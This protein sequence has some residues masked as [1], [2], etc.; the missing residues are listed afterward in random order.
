MSLGLDDGLALG[1]A[2]LVV[3]APVVGPGV[4][5]PVRVPG[6]GDPVGVPGVSLGL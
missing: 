1:T 5:D 6:V 2:L 3:S 4:G